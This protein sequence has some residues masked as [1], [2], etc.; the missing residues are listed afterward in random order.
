MAE[1]LVRHV[2]LVDDNPL[3]LKVLC[4]AIQKAGLRCHTCESA[5]EA[6]AYLAGQKPDLILS[7]YQMPEMN[8]LEFRQYVLS[9]DTL[10]DIPF[11]FLTYD[12]DQDVMIKGLGMQAADYIL[13]NTPV[14]VIITKINNL[15]HTVETQRQLSAQELKRAAEALNVRS[16]PAKAPTA[17]GFSLDFWH[18][19]YQDIPGGDFIDFVEVENRYTFIV[20]GDIMGKKWTA[21]FF[22]FSFLS[23]LRA[24]IR[25]GVFNQDY[26][27]ASILQKVNSVICEDEV[28][29]DMMASTALLMLDRQTGLVSYSGAGDLPLL[30]YEA[31]TGE[32]QQIRS[33]GLLLGLFADGGYDEQQI[34]LQIGDRL[35]LFTDGLIDFADNEGK[36]TDYKLFAQRLHPLLQQRISFTELKNTLFNLSVSQQ[37]DDSS[38]IHIERT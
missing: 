18:R 12:T 7:D 25:F 22:T 10:K 35:L 9:D 6:I 23:Y 3:F 8:G 19:S 2:L 28:L 29:K 33:S 16:V 4:H 1:A 24:A 38:I 32:L 21:W 20:L 31:I 34:E 15:L 26:S 36:K 14:N 5:T 11:V 27:T 37:V 30:K 13:K 17:D